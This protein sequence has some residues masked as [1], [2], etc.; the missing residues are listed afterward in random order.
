M[1]KVYTRNP[2]Y[3]KNIF[4]GNCLQD[5]WCPTV[6]FGCSQFIV[7]LL[8]GM[9]VMMMLGKNNRAEGDKLEENAI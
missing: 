7:H 5:S 2:N 6:S 1:R 4:K 8:V 3:V 9:I